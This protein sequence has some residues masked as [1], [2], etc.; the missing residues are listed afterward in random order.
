M[1]LGTVL[2]DYVCHYHQK[3]WLRIISQT[4]MNKT[5]AA[6]MNILWGIQ[7]KAKLVS[8]DDVDVYRGS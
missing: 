8:C 2:N 6:E 4:V 3:V 1:I 7:L 5:K